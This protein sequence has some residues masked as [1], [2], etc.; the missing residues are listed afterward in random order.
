MKNLRYST[1]NYKTEDALGNIVL[2]NSLYKTIRKYEK[3]HLADIEALMS[4]PDTQINKNLLKD[5]E[6][7]S[8]F[9]KADTD[10]VA[11]SELYYL[12][13]VSR[14]NFN[15]TIVPTMSSDCVWGLSSEISD[16]ECHVFNHVYNNQIDRWM[17]VDPAFG[18]CVIGK[19]TNYIDVLQ[20]R[21]SIKNQTEIF[22]K[23]SKHEHH[24]VVI[25]KRYLS[26]IPKNL[27]M[28]G[29]FKTSGAIYEPS[30]NQYCYVVPNGYE[31]EGYDSFVFTNN[32]NVLY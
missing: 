13:E 32:I 30:K 20:L 25:T 12:N 17:V 10:E 6:M 28:F 18:F 1:F 15:L 23:K 24:S 31:I 22:C 16:T 3:K 4:N 27:F 14:R 29:T 7:C 19:S 8:F 9:V 2:Y 11:I 21:E 26:Y 5:L